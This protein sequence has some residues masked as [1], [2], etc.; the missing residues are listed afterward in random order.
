MGLSMQEKKVLTRE[1]SK[2]HQKSNRKEKTQILDVLKRLPR[3]SRKYVL[4]VLVNW[5]NHQCI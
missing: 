1:L 3:Y 2:Q 5:G 4:Y